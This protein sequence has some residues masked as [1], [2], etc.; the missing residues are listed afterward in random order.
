MRILHLSTSDSSGGAARAAFRLHNGLCQLGVD[1][2]MLV[3]KKGSRDE[4]VVRLRPDMRPTARLRRCFRRR[5]I[6]RDFRAYQD[7][8]PPGYEL[9]SDDRNEHGGALLRRI[10]PCDLINLHWV[11]N[12]LDHPSFFRGAPPV[13]LV[14]RLADMAPLTGGC[15]YDDGCGRFTAQCGACPQLGSNDQLDL[16]RRIWLRKRDALGTV[17]S[18]RLTLVA[19]SNWIAQQAAR[20]ALLRDLPVHVIPNGLDVED[21]APRDKRFARAT[22]GLPAEARIVLFAADTIDVPRKGLAL[23]LQ[24]LGGLV[25]KVEDLLLLSVG[26]G[27]PVVD[28]PCRHQHLGSINIDRYLSLAY[29]AA[30]VFVIPSIQESFGQTVS[31][32]LA[33]GTPVVGFATGG[34]LDMVRPGVTGRLVEVGDA[35]GLGDAIRSMLG[36]PQ[37]LREMSAHCRRIAVA[38]YSMQVQA[39]AY[40]HLYASLLGIVR[41]SV[42]TGP[43]APATV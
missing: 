24:A 3:S 38:E 21:F 26:H 11:S 9:F 41:P 18:G 7:S 31:E 34:M 20:S 19:T 33:C 15:H 17:A 42:N 10:P 5:Q 29:S 1:S 22:L 8:R 13:P 12:F 16:S 40:R 28:G 43:A 35:A 6:Q 39:R 23:L 25:G 4:R 2:T 37:G 14:W 27:K 30:D 36:N 32:S